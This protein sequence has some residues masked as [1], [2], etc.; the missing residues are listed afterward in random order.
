ML[1]NPLA[2]TLINRAIAQTAKVKGSSLEAL[3]ILTHTSDSTANIKKLLLHMST[4]DTIILYMIIQIAKF[5]SIS[6]TQDVSEILHTSLQI[7]HDNRRCMHVQSLLT[8]M[9]MLWPHASNGN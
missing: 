4:Y 6:I 3:D 8:Y 1:L 7:Y 5:L 2:L 9:H